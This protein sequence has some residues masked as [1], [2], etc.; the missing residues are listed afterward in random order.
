[1]AKKQRN[2]R[3]LNRDPENSFLLR[4]PVI[5]AALLLLWP[6]GIILLITK[7]IGVHRKKRDEKI[8]TSS[9]VP[10]AKW[11]TAEEK[12]AYGA[13]KRRANKR[14]L[15]SLLV[16]GIFLVIG[17]VGITLDYLDL[18]RGSGLHGDFIKDFLVHSA[19]LGVGVF[20]CSTAYSIFLQQRRILQL[21]AIIGSAEQVTV[22]SLAAATG[23][24]EQVICG[25]LNAMLEQ[26]Y[27]GH[28]ACFDEAAGLLICRQ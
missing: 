4:W 23:Y 6:L 5:L 13:A 16:T 11:K 1:M 20:L 26:Q 7:F 15:T 22:A 28:N 14:L 12:Q 18:F 10:Y 9:S 3:T 19:F 27:F 2:H 24:A 17:C 21:S 25:D 8:R